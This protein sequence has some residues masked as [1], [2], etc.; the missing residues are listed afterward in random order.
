ME[1]KKT[2]NVPALQEFTCHEERKTLLV[3]CSVTSFCLIFNY[4]SPDLVQSNN[5]P[6]QI[7]CLVFHVAKDGK[8]IHSR[9]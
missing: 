4:H 1:V 6:S 9:H 5:I 7:I 2:S 8:V 3:T